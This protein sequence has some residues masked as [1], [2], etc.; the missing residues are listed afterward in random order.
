MRAFLNVCRHRGSLLVDG[1][2]N[3]EALQCP[4]HAWTYDLDGSL[5]AAAALDREPD[6]ETEGLSLVPLRTE[7]WGP[8][9]FVN[10]DDGG[11]AARGD[12]RSASPTS[13]PV[14]GLVFHV[15]RRLRARAN[16]KIA[17]E[18]YLRVLPLPGRT[19]GLQR[20]R[21]DVD[22]GRVPARASS[23]ACP[24]RSSRRRAGRARR[25][26]PLRLAE[27]QAE[28]LRG[29]AEPLDRPA[30]ARRAGALD[31]LPRL[32]LRAGRAIPA[33]VDELLELDRQVGAE[34][35]VLVERVQKGVR[36]GH[37]RRRV[38]S[39]WRASSSSARF[40]ELVASRRRREHG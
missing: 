24:L 27:P 36:S 30:A 17:C 6:F 19:Q 32:L 23:G 15:A 28:R 33:W 2:G 20:Q 4:Y 38:S 26:V 25:A 13:C 29:Q 21:Y 14:D 7:S 1:E 40:Q 9:L 22:P 37:G 8:F 11:A 12:A 35:R 34:D 31:R 18:N 16:W 5:R 39:W 3:R 10:P